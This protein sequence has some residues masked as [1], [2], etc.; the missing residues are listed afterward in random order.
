VVMDTQVPDDMM[1]ISSQ[2][3]V[4]AQVLVIWCI[5]PPP[6]VVDTQVPYDM[7]HISSQMVVDTQ[8]LAIWCIFPP[9]WW[10]TYKFLMIWCIF[11]PQWQMRTHIS[12]LSLSS[13][14][15]TR[16]ENNLL[17]AEVLEWQLKIFRGWVTLKDLF[18]L[19]DRTK[20]NIIHKFII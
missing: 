19:C 7:M 4:D 1:H 16:E 11:P 5:F 17:T 6:V 14:I 2:M 10:W 9:K 13:V 3:V 8:V 18:N 15:A 20:V 12:F